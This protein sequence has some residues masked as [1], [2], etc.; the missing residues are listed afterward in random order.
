MAIRFSFY[1]AAGRTAALRC[2]GQKKQRRSFRSRAFLGLK[3]LSEA[4]EKLCGKAFTDCHAS[5]RT[6]SQ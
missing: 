3:R 1:L 5:V 2:R 4:G 6:G